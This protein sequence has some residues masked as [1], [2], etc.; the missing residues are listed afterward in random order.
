MEKE[1]YCQKPVKVKAIQWTGKNLEEVKDFLHECKIPASCFAIQENNDCSLVFNRLGG[2]V[3]NVKL[4]DYIIVNERDLFILFPQEFNEIYTLEK[5]QESDEIR[6]KY[7]REFCLEELK[8]KLEVFAKD[9]YQIFF[10]PAPESTHY[11]YSNKYFEL[12]SNDKGY[13][14]VLGL[15]DEEEEQIKLFYN[16]LIEQY[17]KQRQKQKQ[18]EQITKIAREFFDDCVKALSKEPLISKIIV[19]DDLLKRIQE[20]AY[21]ATPTY[22]NKGKDPTFRKNGIKTDLEDGVYYKGVKVGDV[23]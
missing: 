1:V 19:L 21:L 20:G 3:F 10:A 7:Y 16:K 9:D 11:E 6:E 4:L 18:E 5:P 14:D 23:D 12:Y 2:E 8:E 17:E 13:I 15:N 22:Y